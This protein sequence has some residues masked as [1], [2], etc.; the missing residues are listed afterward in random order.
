MICARGRAVDKPPAA[1]VR[2]RPPRPAAAQVALN[3]IRAKGAIPIPGAR[4]LRQATQNVGALDWALGS[5]ELAALDRAAAPLE[6]LLPPDASPFPKK[7]L[8]T[9]MELFDS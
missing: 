2:R 4:N 3:W 8:F 7:D 5:A 1:F 6:P 9:G